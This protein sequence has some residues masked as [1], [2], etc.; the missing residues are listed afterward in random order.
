MADRGR[1]RAQ[2][3]SKALNKAAADITVPPMALEDADLEQV[4]PDSIRRLALAI[5]QV[6]F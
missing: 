6:G 1:K 3:E 2:A 5:G 4:V